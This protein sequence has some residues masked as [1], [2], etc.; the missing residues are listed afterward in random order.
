[1][2]G[3]SESNVLGTGNRE[4]AVEIRGLVKRYGSTVAVN[5]L[6]L[7]IPKGGVYAF[8]GPNGSG[9]TTTLKMLVGL[10]EPTSGDIRVLGE[11]PGTL[12][13][14]SRV[15]ALIESPDFYPYLS[16]KDNLRVVARCSGVPTSRAEEVLRQV[17]LQKRAKDAF[18]K[19]SLGMKQRLGVAAA[20]L[21]NPELVILDEPANGLDA[22]GIAE[23][24][25]LLRK[26]GEEGR[27]VLFSS[28]LMAEVE[29][30]CDRVGVIKDGRLVAEGDAG[31]LRSQ[32]GLEIKAEP[33]EEASRLAADVD[34][35][36]EVRISGERLLLSADPET[37]PEVVHALDGAGVRVSEV[38]PSGLSLE[39]LFL[40]LTEDAE[41]AD[42]G[43]R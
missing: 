9:K 8:L 40:R 16:G 21:K 18:K 11:R 13:S 39:E 35:V 27:T 12:S 3:L 32:G 14:L 2:Q 20:L 4:L 26:L 6:D 41:S 37:A 25:I 23:M 22:K 33:L 5:N 28:H 31:D 42:G 7:G 24:R 19:Y 38:R 34:G 10:V 1:M 29:Q 15:G 17:G 36:E 43:G 30:I